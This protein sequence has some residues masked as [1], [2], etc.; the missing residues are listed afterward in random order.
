MPFCMYIQYNKTSSFQNYANYR[1]DNVKAI[2]YDIVL[3]VFTLVCLGLLAT[4]ILYYTNFLLQQYFSLKGK[5]I[6]L[7]P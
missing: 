7:S 4:F 6:V 1:F 5:I 3:F 2:Q